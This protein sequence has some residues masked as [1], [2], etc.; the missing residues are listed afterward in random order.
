MIR[1]GAGVVLRPLRDD[2]APAI[3]HI[4]AEPEVSHWWLRQTWERIVEDGSVS[5]AIEADG[6]VAGLIQYHEE[7]DPDYVSAAVDLFV[8][9]R[10]AG[11]HV[12]RLA[13]QAV[14][15]HL[16]RERGHH[17]ITVD[18]AADN[19]RAIHVYEALGFR[20]VGVMHAYERGANGW[21]DG[22]LMELVVDAD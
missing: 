13:L 19:A 7:L 12:G 18:P 17:R 20:T 11:R 8:S 1:A 21:H 4:L 22:L 14:V 6:E 10:F 5:F 2:D 16:V 3:S 9:D 15:D